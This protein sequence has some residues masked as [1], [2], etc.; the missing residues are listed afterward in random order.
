MLCFTG[1]SWLCSALVCPV[2]LKC[3]SVF[4]YVLFHYW[5]VFI[6]TCLSPSWWALEF[7]S[8]CY[9]FS[10]C[11]ICSLPYIFVAVECS[12]FV[13]S[14]RIKVK[15]QTACNVWLKTAWFLTADPLWCFS[16]NSP[17]Q[18]EFGSFCLFCPKFS[19]SPSRL[20]PQ[21]C[22]LK[23]L[24]NLTRENLLCKFN[25][26]PHYTIKEIVKRDGNRAPGVFDM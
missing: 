12:A 5:D 4:C 19:F 17:K 14:R 13:K 24:K 16:Y 23:S 2:S 9:C 15:W 11:F 6:E 26:R 21:L 8:P 1:N 22:V 20:M 7:S 18:N 25:A 10:L 3:L